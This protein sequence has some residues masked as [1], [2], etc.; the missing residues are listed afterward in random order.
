M[1]VCVNFM[2]KSFSQSV[3]EPE[4]LLSIYN[5]STDQSKDD[6]HLETAGVYVFNTLLVCCYF[7]LTVLAGTLFSALISGVFNP[8]NPVRFSKR[9]V[10]V[11]I[12]T[13][14]NSNIHKFTMTKNDGVFFVATG[15]ANFNQKM[16]N[17]VLMKSDKPFASS[18]RNYTSVTTETTSRDIVMRLKRL[19]TLHFSS[20]TG[21]AGAMERFIS[22][23][24]FNIGELMSSDNEP[25]V[26]S[27]ARTSFLSGIA[28][29]VPF[30]QILVN[31]Y[32]HYNVTSNKF[33]AP[34]HGIYFFS[35]S[36][37]ISGG[38]AVEFVLYINDQPFTSIIRQSTSYTGTDVIGR[39]ILTF[40]NAGD[41]VHVVNRENKVA[42]S[43]KLLETSF[44]GF[45]YQPVY[46]E[47]VSF[48][49]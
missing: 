2:K 16:L 14:W 39:S 13:M 38:L 40:L 17:F 10:L 32:L 11:N 45:Q 5:I 43:S 46:A 9:N 18:S 26:F 41:T 33:T 37:G 24:I 47:R 31:D 29:P 20:T 22:I 12:G 7:V 23:G 34:S 15:A 36:V 19:D 27:V 44:S 42:W 28:D 49:F 4:F 6:Y 1:C 3:S 30:N 25:V 35:W 8:S 21:L 48:D